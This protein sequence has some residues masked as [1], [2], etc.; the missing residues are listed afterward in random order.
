MALS[1]SEKTQL[2]NLLNKGDL[3]GAAAILNAKVPAGAKPGDPPAPPPPPP[4][5]RD[6]KYVIMDLFRSIHQLLGNSPAMVALINELDELV[7]PPEK[8]EPAEK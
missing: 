7:N 5:P 2:D 8:E 1:R 3:A 6:P 4:E